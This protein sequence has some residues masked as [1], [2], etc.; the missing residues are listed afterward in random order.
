MAGVLYVAK[1]NENLDKYIG[2]KVQIQANYLMNETNS[3]SIRTNTQCIMDSCQPIF[4]DSNQTTYA[5]VIEK[6]QEIAQ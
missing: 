1:S 4:E 5:I 3:D 2:K 6:V